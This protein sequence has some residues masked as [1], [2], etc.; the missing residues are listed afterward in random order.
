MKTSN[1]NPA[2][3]MAAVAIVVA[4]LVSMAWINP[5]LFL[6]YQTKAEYSAYLTE[7]PVVSELPHNQTEPPVTEPAAGLTPN[8]IILDSGES[9]DWDELSEKD[10]AKI[11]EALHTAQLAVRESM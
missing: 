11:R 5:P 1:V 10:K 7:S 6:S 4:A 3:K 9:V 8:R 2:Q